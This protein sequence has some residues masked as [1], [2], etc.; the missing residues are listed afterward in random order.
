MDD[1]VTW[2]KL[3]RGAEGKVVA[4]LPLIDHCLDVA[5]A[6]AAILP[7][8]MAV[9]QAAAGRE[10][11]AQDVARLTVLVALLVVTNTLSV[12]TAQRAR[13]LALLR[14]VGAERGQVVRAVVG[15]GVI[16][17]LAGTVLGLGVGLGVG[18][19]VGVQGG[20]DP[21]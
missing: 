20:A 10:L 7:A 5:A 12:L 6:F 3:E 8:W 19:V 2:A 11:T 18:V 13:E 17:G 1:R 15:E 14:A 16:V 4:A 21:G 9:L